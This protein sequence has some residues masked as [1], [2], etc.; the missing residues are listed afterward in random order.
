M[1]LKYALFGL[2]LS[3][4]VTAGIELPCISPAEDRL[5]RVQAIERRAWAWKCFPL[6]RERWKLNRKSGYP[7]LAFVDENREVSNPENW[8]APTDSR[9]A[10]AVPTGYG[11]VDYYWVGESCDF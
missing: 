4:Q 5:N 11:I 7:T 1:K 10:C 2:L 6:E 9:A 8:F 3:G